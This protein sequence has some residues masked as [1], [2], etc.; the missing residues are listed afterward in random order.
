MVVDEF[1]T[2]IGAR[3]GKVIS[4]ASIIEPQTRSQAEMISRSDLVK[5]HVA[6]MPDAHFG[7]G[8]CVGSAIVTEGGILPS[9]VGVD[10]GC[11]MIAVETSVRRESVQEKSARKMLGSIRKLIPAGVGQGHEGTTEDW[12]RFHAEYGDAPGADERILQRVEEANRG[13]E[14]ISNPI[15]SSRT[16]IGTAGHASGSAS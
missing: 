2:E 12:N 11:G 3:K 1:V 16:P 5:G 9:A 6:L 4:W 15:S 10:I 13:C 7:L 14:R 8:A